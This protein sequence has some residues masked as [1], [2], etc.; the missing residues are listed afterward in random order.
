LLRL[1]TGAPTVL[2]DELSIEPAQAA[3]DVVAIAQAPR[4]RMSLTVSAFWRLPRSAQ[5]P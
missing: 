1:E 4:L 3:D 2:V 5:D